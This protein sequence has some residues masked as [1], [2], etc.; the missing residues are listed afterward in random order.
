MDRNQVQVKAGICL[1]LEPELFGINFSFTRAGTGIPKSQIN[2]VY[3]SFFAV[4]RAVFKKLI[5]SVRD[6]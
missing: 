2:F 4:N 6:Y 1:F 3:E 5:C